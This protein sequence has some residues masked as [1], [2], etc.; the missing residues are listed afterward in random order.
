MEILTQVK[1]YFSN[2]SLSVEEA[3][4]SYQLEGE[5][6]FEIED[7]TPSAEQINLTEIDTAGNTFVSQRLA[8][9]L[10][11]KLDNPNDSFWENNF[12]EN[13][14]NPVLT[15]ESN[16]KDFFRG[17][18]IKIENVGQDGTMMLLNLASSNSK[19]YN[20][21]HFRQYHNRR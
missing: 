13:Q 5:L 9:A 2:A 6:L 18:Y 17:L 14:N 1:V 21:L 3:I 11:F 16:F 8:P 19:T 10:R 15:N 4:D 12:F 20:T 7:F